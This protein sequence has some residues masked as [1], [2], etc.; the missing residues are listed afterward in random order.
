MLVENEGTF[1]Q[2][3]DCPKT[4]YKKLSNNCTG[5]IE[6]S[7]RRNEPVAESRQ[8]KVSEEKTIA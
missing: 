1:F 5:G 7:L 8:Q 3:Q 2:D 4:I 6:S